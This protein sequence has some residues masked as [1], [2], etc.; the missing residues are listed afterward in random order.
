MNDRTPLRCR[1]KAC[2]ALGYWDPA[3]P[4][5]PM[6]AGGEWDLPRNPELQESWDTD[7]GRQPG[8]R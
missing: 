3:D 8:S 4:R 7:S 5:C 6:H 2:P 1:V